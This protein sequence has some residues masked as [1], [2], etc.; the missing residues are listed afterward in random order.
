[1]HLN[2]YVEAAMK[3]QGIYENPRE[4]TICALMGIGGESGELLDAFKKKMFHSKPIGD[5]ELKKEVG[6]LLWY[7][8]LLCDARQWDFDEIAAMNIAKLRARYPDGFSFARANQARL[9]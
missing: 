7:L 9:A 5:D 8:A 6:D 4:Q 1:M 3:T 2:E